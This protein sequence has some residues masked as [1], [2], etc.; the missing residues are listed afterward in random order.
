LQ[1]ALAN[2]EFYAENPSSAASSK[3]NNVTFRGFSPK[4]ILHQ[5][6]S[7]FTK[8]TPYMI[9]ESREKM[10]SILKS[11]KKEQHSS[12]KE[13]QRF[14]V[15]SFNSI[16]QSAVKAQQMFPT[17]CGDNRSPSMR[18]T[19]QNS[20][21]TVSQFLP[22]EQTNTMSTHHVRQNQHIEQGPS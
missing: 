17:P 20:A 16:I 12:G 13:N 3:V 19:G 14:Q 10:N 21:V 8:E 18:S 5:K 9:K 11:L 1:Q 2:F 7:E 6:Q 15:N 22:S 4:I